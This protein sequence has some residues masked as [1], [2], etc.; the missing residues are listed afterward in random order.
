M[1]GGSEQGIP[2]NSTLTSTSGPHESIP[3]RPDSPITVMD[4]ETL[5]FARLYTALGAE[6]TYGYLKFSQDQDPFANM[7]IPQD[8]AH[9]MAGRLNEEDV[10][11]NPQGSEVL[12]VEPLSVRPPSSSTTKLPLIHST[13]SSSQ[14]AGTAQVRTHVDKP[15]EVLTAAAKCMEPKEVPFSTMT[16]N[17][18]PLFWRSKVIRK[19]A[20]DPEIP[21]EKVSQPAVAKDSEVAHFTNIFEKRPAPTEVRPRLFSKRQKSI[22]HKLPRSEI[23]DLTEDLPFSIP[24][25]QEAPVDS[26]NYNPSTSDSLP[27]EG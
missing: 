13:P 21:V 11:E 17:H 4:L 9:T 27:E 22:S 24:H 1:S 16:G 15:D 6:F 25:S 19:S 7:A 18:V 20:K 2:L 14:T 5:A 10:R 26:F 12:S 3:Q 8:V 23:L